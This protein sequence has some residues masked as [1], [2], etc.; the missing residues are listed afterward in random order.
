MTALNGCAFPWQ[1]H[2]REIIFAEL[3]TPKK[4]RCM[5]SRALCCNTLL[6]AIDTNKEMYFI[7]AG[8]E[9]ECDVAFALTKCSYEADSEVRTNNNIS[10]V[11]SCTVI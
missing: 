9:D 7:S 10:E 3:L 5:H 2:F 4:Q 8:I 6:V 11:F 1:T